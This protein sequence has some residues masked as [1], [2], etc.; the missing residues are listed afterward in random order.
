MIDDSNLTF[1]LQGYRDTTQAQAALRSVRN[2]YP[3]A[4][5][6]LVSDGDSSTAWRRLAS[7]FGAELTYGSRLYPVKN[8]GRMI[9]RMLDLYLASP[10]LWL[11]KLDTDSRVHRPF[12]HLPDKVSLFGTLEWETTKT[13]EHLDFPNLQGGCIGFTRSAAEAITESRLLLSERLL[14]PVSTFADTKDIQQRAERY[15]LVSFDF[16][17]RWVC[18]ELNI[19]MTNHSEIHTV[20]RGRHPDDGGG[21]AVTHP[22]K[23]PPSWL[24]LT[25]YRWWIRRNFG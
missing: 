9:Q 25:R 21:F 6:L 24:S 4:R 16:I 20:Y 23:V 7:R 18:R 22:H 15:G 3:A 10:T 12:T 14:D 13:R 19:S 11:I 2:V 17:L 5:V 8:G 1:Y